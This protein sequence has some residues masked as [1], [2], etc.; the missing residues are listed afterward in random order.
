MSAGDSGECCY[1][2]CYCDAVGEAHEQEAGCVVGAAVEAD[3]DAG[4][5]DGYEYEGEDAEEFGG[6]GS[7]GFRFLELVGHRRGGSCG[8][9][10]SLAQGAGG[11]RCEVGVGVV[12]E[13]IIGLPVLICG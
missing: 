1:G 4:C 6:G 2:Y 11:T 3:G 12:V 10:R 7:P 9:T 13:D 8:H 5:S